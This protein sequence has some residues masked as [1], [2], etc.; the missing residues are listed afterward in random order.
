MANIEKTKPDV[1][2]AGNIGCIVQIASGIGVPVVHTVQLVDW[3]TGA[4]SRRHSA[5]GTGP[6][7]RRS[8][9]PRVGPASVR[10]HPPRVFP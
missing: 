9:V 7:L 1:V 5:S 2:A 10:L 8:A 3:A 6:L 4:P